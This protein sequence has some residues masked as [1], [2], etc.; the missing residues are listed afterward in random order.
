MLMHSLMD[1]S[2]RFLAPNQKLNAISLI[3]DSEG[4]LSDDPSYAKVPKMLSRTKIK[5]KHASVVD[6]FFVRK[7]KNTY[8]SSY[9]YEKIIFNLL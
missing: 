3:S 9:I 1:D 8:L 4:I 5:Q 2:E 7:Y 6:K